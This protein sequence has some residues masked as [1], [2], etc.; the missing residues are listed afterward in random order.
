MSVD[1]S[2]SMKDWG[3]SCQNHC[4]TYRKWEPIDNHSP[5]GLFS[6]KIEL[7]RFQ[8]RKEEF[9]KCLRT[10]TNKKCV[11]YEHDGKHESIM[12][13]S[14]AACSRWIWRRLR[15]IDR[16]RNNSVCIRAHSS[17]V[18]LNVC[19]FSVQ[20][21]NRFLQVIPLVLVIFAVDSLTLKYKTSDVQLRLSNIEWQSQNMER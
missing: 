12:K 14:M 3:S 1:Q 11:T 8:I 18:N 2:I 19:L 17:I 16:I 20:M 15:R 6:W 21:T 7:V 9:G 13:I 4:N 10:P 5:T